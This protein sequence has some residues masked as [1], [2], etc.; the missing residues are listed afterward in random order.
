LTSCSY[1]YGSE[2]ANP[3]RATMPPAATKLPGLPS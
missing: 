3:A 2:V 1:M